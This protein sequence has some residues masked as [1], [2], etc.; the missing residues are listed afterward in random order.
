MRGLIQLAVVGFIG[1]TVIHFLVTVY[2]RSVR[3]EELEKEW[4]GNPPEGGGEAE[5]A[6][7][8][9][10]GMRAYEHSLRRKVIVLV[11][12]VPIVIFAVTVYLVNF[13]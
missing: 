9:E 12:I 11:Y 8:I 3:R 13:Q 1:L 2:S 4:D 7:F 6:A 10:A 5:R